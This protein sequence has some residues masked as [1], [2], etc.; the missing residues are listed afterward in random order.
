MKKLFGMFALAAIFVVAMATTAFASPVILTSGNGLPHHVTCQGQ[1]NCN[2]NNGFCQIAVGDLVAHVEGNGP[3]TL[4]VNGVSVRTANNNFNYRVDL[5]N[6]Y[7]L[8][9]R[10]Q[11][12]K[13]RFGGSD[14]T[15]VIPPVNE[16]PTVNT[17]QVE[18]SRVV[19]RELVDAD[20]SAHIIQSPGNTNTVVFGA[21]GYIMS[22][23]TVTTR[24][25]YHWS[26]GS[27]TFGPPV[28]TTTTIMEQA[29]YSLRYTH[30]N[31]FFN[32][33]REIQVGPFVV[34]FQPI[35]NTDVRVF[36]FVRV[37][38]EFLFE[39]NT[40]TVGRNFTGNICQSSRPS[41]TWEMTQNGRRGNSAWNRQGR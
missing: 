4:F 26:N 9:I 14:G 32:V 21:I 17:R 3:T 36:Q 16:A 37:A 22:T 13:I 12:N 6:G 33:P 39:G 25:E 30:Q 18:V 11:G 20:F 29:N 5:P 38:P 19:S 41:V 8:D 1:A 35:G 34:V 24:T 15:R 10:V 31:N 40:V 28:A 27:I 7:V 23:T 2:S